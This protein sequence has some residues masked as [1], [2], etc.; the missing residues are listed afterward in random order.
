MAIVQ[1]VV[2]PL[3]LLGFAAWVSVEGLGLGF[4]VKCLVFRGWCGLE[5]G[6]WSLGFGVEGLGLRVWGVGLRVEG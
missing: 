6:V 4:R 1:R 2:L 5:F 3:L